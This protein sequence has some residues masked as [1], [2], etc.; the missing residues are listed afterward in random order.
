MEHLIHEHRH[1][2]ELT[3]G[4]TAP[5]SALIRIERTD[6]YTHEKPWSTC[7]CLG[8]LWIKYTTSDRADWFSSLD[9]WGNPG[10]KTVEY[11][12]FYSGLSKVAHL[13][14]HAGGAAHCNTI[15]YYHGHCSRLEIFT[16]EPARLCYTPK[17]DTERLA[18]FM[19]IQTS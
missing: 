7:S 15:F 1:F 16:S 17:R 4:N 2:G 8:Q 9:L 3:R 14:I 18:I 5:L 10:C 12:P 13:I 19:C 11:F 6:T